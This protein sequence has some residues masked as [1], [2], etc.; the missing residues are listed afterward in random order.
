MQS[1]NYHYGIY[2]F[3]NQSPLSIFVKMLSV[4]MSIISMSTQYR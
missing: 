4:K 2:K 3:T 1:S